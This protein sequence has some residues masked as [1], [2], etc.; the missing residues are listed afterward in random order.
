MDILIRVILMI[1]CSIIIPLI[2]KLLYSPLSE[3][4]YKELNKSEKIELIPYGL[5][6]IFLFNWFIITPSIVF[7][8]CLKYI[9]GSLT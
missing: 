3:I 2:G 1:I 8:N 5:L 6:Y 9:L 4:K 7:F